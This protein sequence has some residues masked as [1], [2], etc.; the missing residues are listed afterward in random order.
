MHIKGE[1]FHHTSTVAYNYFA[2]QL[3]LLD[4]QEVSQFSFT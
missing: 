2:Q 4:F 1:N 3:I